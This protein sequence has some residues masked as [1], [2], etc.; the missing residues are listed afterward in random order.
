M[1]FFAI[2]RDVR[3][4][5]WAKNRVMLRE[6]RVKITTHF[7]KQVLRELLKREFPAKSREVAIAGKNFSKWMML[8]KWIGYLEPEWR[9][10]M[11]IRGKASELILYSYNGYK[12]YKL[13]GNKA[14][15][16]FISEDFNKYLINENVCC[17]YY[18]RYNYNDNYDDM[19]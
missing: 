4:I 17:D 1:D 7:V 10:C 6:E 19:Q 2:P 5:I 18:D 3:D 13:C 11:E 16:A 8:S 9:N 15:E 12:E 14:Y